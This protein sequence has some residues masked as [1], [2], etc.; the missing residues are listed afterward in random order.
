MKALI[1]FGVRNWPLVPAVAILESILVDMPN[2]KEVLLSSLAVTPSQLTFLSTQKL[3]PHQS[4]RVLDI[5]RMQREAIS[6]FDTLDSTNEWLTS[7]LQAL[8][9]HTPISL[10]DTF[11]GR[12]IVSDVLVNI[13]FGEFS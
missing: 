3:N 11:V 4:E 8:D 13:R 12:S 6:V 5:V 7:N 1:C 10:L 2:L 9:G